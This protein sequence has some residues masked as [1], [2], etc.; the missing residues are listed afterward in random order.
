MG[1]GPGR[2]SASGYFTKGTVTFLVLLTCLPYGN[3]GDHVFNFCGTLPDKNEDCAKAVMVR[4]SVIVLKTSCHRVKSPFFPPRYPSQE[5]ISKRKPAERKPLKQSAFA[6]LAIS[7]HKDQQRELKKVVLEMPLGLLTQCLV[8]ILWHGFFII[9]VSHFTTILPHCQTSMHARGRPARVSE[10]IL[11]DF[12]LLVCVCVCASSFHAS[13]SET[14]PASKKL[15]DLLHMYEVVQE[16]G[17][18]LD[19]RSFPER[20]GNFDLAISASRWAICVLFYFSFE[21]SWTSNKHWLQ[22]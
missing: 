3:P 15:E 2:R 13:A 11:R 21:M 9:G 14:T 5:L 1:A 22:L 4:A 18:S 10:M 6:R 19:R 12:L 7:H 20:G 8:F 16:N 17:G